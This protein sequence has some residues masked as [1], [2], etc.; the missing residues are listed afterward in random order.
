MKKSIVISIIMFCI[1]G[2]FCGD[3][4][5][6][7]ASLRASTSQVNVGENVSITVSFGDNVSFAQFTLNYDT[8][9]FDYISSSAGGF[10]ASTKKFA[11]MNTLG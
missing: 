6:A 4:K 3:V 11:Y 10:G 2:I 9:K 5:A 7:T 8:S 1:I